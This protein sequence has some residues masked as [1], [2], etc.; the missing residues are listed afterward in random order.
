M[1]D[2]FIGEIRILGFNFPPRG[3]VTCAG[4]TLPIAQNS[5]VFALLG[6]IYGGNGVQNFGIPNL[7]G[8]M[9]V[10][11]GTSTTG[12]AYVIGEAGGSENVN[13]TTNQMPPHNH[14]ATFTTTGLTATTTLNASTKTTGG[15]LIPVPQ[16]T[17][18]ATP[19]GPTSAAI[20]TPPPAPT[21]DIVPLGN[22]TTTIGGNGSVT[23]GVN[24]AGL[25]TPIMSPFLAL[26]FCLAVEGIFPSRN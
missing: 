4:Q 8:R 3:W 11:F 25:P 16:A 18:C 10:S 15:A 24:G 5:A 2:P 6:T 12:T 20:Y 23:V 1:S 17:L 7:Q 14:S 9:P 26:N 19:T 22:V 21:T 13:L